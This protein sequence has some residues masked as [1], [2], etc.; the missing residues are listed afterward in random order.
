MSVSAEGI[1]SYTHTHTQSGGPAPSQERVHLGQPRINNIGDDMEQSD[2]AAL[3]A[4]AVQ[5]VY[6]HD[7]RP[8]LSCEGAGLPE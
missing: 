2:W 5:L 4:A 8:F 6:R 1:S 3:P 7:T